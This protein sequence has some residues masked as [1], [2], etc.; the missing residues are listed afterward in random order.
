MFPSVLFFSLMDVVWS[1][2][3]KKRK[4]AET[5]AC[6]SFLSSLSSSTKR[7]HD[8]PKRTTSCR[9]PP[10]ALC[11]FCPTTLNFLFSQTWRHRID[12]WKR[13]STVTEEKERRVFTVLFHVSGKQE[14]WKDG[15]ME[16]WRGWMR[17]MKRNKRVGC[18]FLC[19]NLT[20]LLLGKFCCSCYSSIPAGSEGEHKNRMETTHK[21]ILVSLLIKDP[22]P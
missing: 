12:D 6:S 21:N 8:I 10:F 18:T 7:T 22:G 20:L 14:E 19:R 11:P 17:R 5:R 9:P 2:K 3:N 15:R 4:N 13:R 16:G 1:T